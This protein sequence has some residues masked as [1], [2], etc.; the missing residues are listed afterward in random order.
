MEQIDAA[1]RLIRYNPKV[2]VVLPLIVYLIVGIVS[3]IIVLIGGE[4][5]YLTT[6]QIVSVDADALSTSATVSTILTAL[7]SFIAG[8]FI[9]TRRPSMRR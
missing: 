1:I 6:S 5:S 8:L 4:A 9:S 2:F 7:V 3:T